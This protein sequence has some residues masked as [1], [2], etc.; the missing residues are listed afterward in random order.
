M[1]LKSAK[2]EIAFVDG[3]QTLQMPFA[4]SPSISWPFIEPHTDS[5]K[6]VFG[7]FEAGSS[8]NGKFVHAVSAWTTVPE[9]LQAMSR[10]SGKEV[11][12]KKIG[13]DAFRKLHPE[14]VAEDL[15]QTMLLVG[16][17]SYYGKGEAKAQKG[18]DWWLLEGTKPLGLEKMVEATG[19]W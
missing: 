7:L 14:V 2:D 15:T 8:A 1:Y 9:L 16:N 18:H 10:A 3:K 17:Y 4:N 13:I 6:Y 12:F 5:G 19:P 11:V